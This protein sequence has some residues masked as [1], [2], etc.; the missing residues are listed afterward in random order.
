[1]TGSR[2]LSTMARRW[3]HTAVTVLRKATTELEYLPFSRFI[4]FS[5]TMMLA[6]D[7]LHLDE[8]F[9]QEFSS[10]LSSEDLEVLPVP[11]QTSE[12]LS[13]TERKRDFSSFLTPWEPPATHL[14]RLASFAPSDSMSPH[15]TESASD[16]SAD[17]ESHVTN[18]EEISLKR[19]SRLEK[20]RASATKCR[21]KKRNEL[22][23][24][25]A[26]VTE[27]MKKISELTQENAALRADNAS[28][29]DHNRFL[30]GLLASKPELPFHTPQ[31]VAL[32]SRQA[33][34][35]ASG[36]AILGIVGAFTMFSRNGLLGT[37]HESVGRVLENPLEDIMRQQSGSQFHILIVGVFLCLVLYA[38]ISYGFYH[39]I[40]TS[41]TAKR[42]LLP[43]HK[44]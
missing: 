17:N 35:A 16:C 31:D 42:E 14:L 15:T 27:F 13:M 21:L 37:D 5:S 10:D 23:T 11:M 28:L 12:C 29:T 44:Q 32:E 9:F 3:D 34:G 6:D 1:M 33:A 25:Q 26:K 43:S 38:T 30:R 39:P 18:N 40:S 22:N 8:N 24:L 7:D 20:N 19:Q 36:I 41:K 2:T 4:S